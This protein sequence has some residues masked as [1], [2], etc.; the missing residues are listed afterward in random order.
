M[1]H[2]MRWCVVRFQAP[3]VGRV[4]AGPWLSM[5]A[6]L[7]GIAALAL[8]GCAAPTGGGADSTSGRKAAAAD[9]EKVLVPH[10]TWTCGMPGGIPKPE[11]GVLVFEADMDLDQILK[12][13]HTPYGERQVL[14]VRG[15][16]ITGGKL[17]GTVLP[18]GLD[19][20]LTLANGTVEVEQLLVF[21]TS[22][23]R[24]VYLRNA[25]VGTHPQD[26]RVVLDAEAPAASTA[27]WLNSGTYV[28]RRV[29]D[30][31]A[32]TLKLQVYDVAGVSTNA[33]PARMVAVVKPANVPAQPWD[34]RKAE[35]AERPGDPIVTESVSLGASLPVGASKHGNRNIIPITG[36]VLTGSITGKVLAGGADY[37]NLTHAPTL[38]ARYLWQTTDG[39]ILIVR[40]TGPFGSLV[41]TF[42]VATGSKYAWLNSGNYLSSSPSMAA[43][44]VG[45]TMYKS[46]P[47]GKG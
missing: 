14:V 5:L 24:L 3:G 10:P 33:D 47:M 39:D 27:A 43:G 34:Y 31:A 21:R 37:Q 17:A 19:F 4:K 13:G 35:P 20:E 26:V 42:E 2:K 29:V 22:E 15:G 9:A 32:K 30:A 38:D 46:R 6:G 36:G 16:T 18:G 23:G 44:G 1:F 45:I 12:V 11:G 8:E 40:N 7:L 41:P 28:A 25:G